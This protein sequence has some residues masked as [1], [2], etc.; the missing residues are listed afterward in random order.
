MVGL[1]WRGISPLRTD[2]IR[3]VVPAGAAILCA[4]KSGYNWMVGPGVP[5]EPRAGYL[6]LAF[7]PR[8]THLMRESWGVSRIRR[9]GYY[10]SFEESV[11]AYTSPLP[12]ITGSEDRGG[13]HICFGYPQAMVWLG[14][15]TAGVGYLYFRFGLRKPIVQG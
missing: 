3:V 4:E 7:F 9:S 10:A 2:G 1:Y 11:R 5:P 6:H 12:I 14:L 15:L 8:G 13:L